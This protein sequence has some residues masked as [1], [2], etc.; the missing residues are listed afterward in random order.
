MTLRK[1]ILDIINNT[2]LY[3]TDPSTPDD[4]HD[5][6]IKMV[7]EDILSTAYDEGLRLMNESY[8]YIKLGNPDNVHVAR[9]H[10]SS[11]LEKEK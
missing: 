11:W 1:R 7:N 8:C 3:W 9:R 2:G 4:I 10:N 5:E 6:L